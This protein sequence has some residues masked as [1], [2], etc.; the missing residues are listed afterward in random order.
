MAD[1][2]KAPELVI[3]QSMAEIH[4]IDNDSPPPTPGLSQSPGLREVP[5]SKAPAMADGTMVSHVFGPGQAA[6]DPIAAGLD[7]AHK[8]LTR[9]ENRVITQTGEMAAGPR[10]STYIEK[11]QPV[12]QAGPA[13][14]THI[15]APADADAAKEP[16]PTGATTETMPAASAAPAQPALPAPTE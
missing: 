16:G 4:G 9:N 13:D 12:Q 1:E 14:Q 15:P 7:V 2:E 3:V 5:N 6:V 11:G 10:P 8:P